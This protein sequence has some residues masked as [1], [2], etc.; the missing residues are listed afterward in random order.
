LSARLEKKPGMV[1]EMMENGVE[2]RS[3]YTEGQKAKCDV[4]AIS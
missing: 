1:V 2:I 3:I 4:I